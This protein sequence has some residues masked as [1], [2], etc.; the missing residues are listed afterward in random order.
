M[1][2]WWAD[3]CSRRVGRF[4]LRM[5]PEVLLCQDPWFWAMNKSS[6]EER[7]VET[8]DSEALIP[9]C[10]FRWSLLEVRRPEESFMERRRLEESFM[11]KRRRMEESFIDTLLR[12]E[13]ED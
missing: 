9:L 12:L 4:S 8:P 7:L 1:S 13:L 10:T 2:L 3:C 6:R 11:D 5:D